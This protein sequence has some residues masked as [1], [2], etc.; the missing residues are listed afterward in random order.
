MAFYRDFAA[1]LQSINSTLSQKIKSCTSN[2]GIDRH[3]EY[4]VICGAILYSSL[5]KSQ[6]IDY[7]KRIINII[8]LDRTNR[9]WKCVVACIIHLCPNIFEYPE[10]INK[11][12]GIKGYDATMNWMLRAIDDYVPFDYDI[13]NPII[14]RKIFACLNLYGLHW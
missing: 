3:T 1:Q 10:H 2:R 8:K 12:A 9:Y 6:R 14:R 11:V 13:S 7:S 5:E 4:L